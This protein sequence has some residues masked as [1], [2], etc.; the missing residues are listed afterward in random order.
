MSRLGDF[1]MQEGLLSL[2]DRRLIHRESSA[3]N[4]S[5]ARS[6]LATGLVNDEELSALL[7]AKTSFRRAA[8]DIFH[9]IDME[10]KQPIPTHVLAWLE[11][12]PLSVKE[13]VLSLA[14]VDPTDSDSVNQ[15]RF[16]SGLR[17]RPVIATRSEILRGLHKI[18]AELPIDGPRLE[19]LMKPQEQGIASSSGA[20][21]QKDGA[22]F[23]SNTQNLGIDL[24]Q[25]S[26]SSHEARVASS[27]HAVAGASLEGSTSKSDKKVVDDSPK[28]EASP[29]KP[30]RLDV[31]L[32]FGTLNES[33]SS[34]GA[35]PRSAH[36]D[37]SVAVQAAMSIL[38]RLALKL[39]LS[40]STE[41]AL[42]KFL[43]AVKKSGLSNGLIVRYQNNVPDVSA[44]WIDTG[45]E[46]TFKL[47]LPE[48]MNQKVLARA[49]NARAT[50]HSWISIDS[51]FGAQGKELLNF[52][53]GATSMPDSLFVI[54]RD[55]GALVCLVSFSGQYDHDGLR[56]I[57]YD[58]LRAFNTRT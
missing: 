45:I 34:F 14:M 25:K 28:S 31:L 15:I 46:S 32:G 42:T 2:S 20:L 22:S 44:H 57:F 1:L 5:F 48:S 8:K 47:G 43:D 24:V 38:N 51:A 36:A 56:Q 40:T 23:K 12:L 7:A 55:Q 54:E 27:E 18:G 53:S 10:M 58:A 6:V 26:Q 9:E 17:V 11:V 4:G 16:F 3:H 19:D 29:R 21:V 37:L 33:K 30:D 49:M 13:G 50:D 41:D 35:Q 39:Q 52:W